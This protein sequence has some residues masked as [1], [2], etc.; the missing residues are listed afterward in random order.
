[1]YRTEPLFPYAEGYY[2][3][4]PRGLE[5]RDVGNGSIVTEKE[6]VIYF[7]ADTPQD[8]K[9]RLIKDYAEYYAKEKAS[10][11]FH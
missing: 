3:I 6:Y 9:D 11:V 7:K 8:I 4:F 10:G 5:K 1:M 2:A